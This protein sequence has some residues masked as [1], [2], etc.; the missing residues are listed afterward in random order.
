[1]MIDP[2]LMNT[3]IKTMAMLFIVLGVLVLV[4]YIMKKVMSP[5]GKGKGELIIKVV[6]SLYLSPKERV[7]VIEISGERI[8]VGITPGNI[9]Y[10]TKLSRYKEG[11]GNIEHAGKGHE[12]IS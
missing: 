11:D 1:M 5:K 7:E 4:L 8:V 2:Q 12:V 3:G 9:N 6:S 10:L